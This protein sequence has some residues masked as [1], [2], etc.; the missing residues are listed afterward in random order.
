MVELH[1]PLTVMEKASQDPSINTC[2]AFQN[3][4]QGGLK[5]MNRRFVMVVVVLVGMML[6][7]GSAPAFAQEEQQ[8]QTVKTIFDYKTELRLTDDQV[9]KIREYL[10]D[11]GKE[12]RIFRAKLTLVDVDL[13]SLIEKDA[14]MGLIKNKIK[15][16]YDIQASIKMADVE[17]ARNINNV[18]RPEQLKKWKEIQAEAR[19]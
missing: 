6:M 15:E 17:A 14:D 9:A 10:N 13:Q 5:S 2:D 12:I 3:K 18:L 11:L 16:A 8:Q 7:A 19:K 4:K 1:Y